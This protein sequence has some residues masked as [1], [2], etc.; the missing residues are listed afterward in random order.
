MQ[1]QP[2]LETPSSSDR[3]Q[4][5]EIQGLVAQGALLLPPQ[6]PVSAFIFLNVLEAFEEIPF[7]EGIRKGAML[8]GC[9][10]YLA[11]DQYQKQLADGRIRRDDLIAEL[12]ADLG[13]RAQE[14]VASLCT[15]LQL[16]EAMLAFALRSGPVDELRWFV[17]ETDALTRIRPEASMDVRERLIISTQQ[18]LQDNTVG[19]SASS[20]A[21][22]SYHR[23]LDDLLRPYGGS[24][25]TWTTEIWEE[26]TLKALWRICREGVHAVKAPWQRTELPIRHRDLLLDATGEDSDALV[27]EVLIRF[28]AAYADQGQA[29]WD[30]PLR[31]QGL[32]RAFIELYRQQVGPPDR[33]MRPLKS[34]LE[35]LREAGLTPAESILESLNLLDVP[36]EEWGDYL[37]A[38]LCALKGWA[39]LLYQMDVRSDRVPLPAKPGTLVEYVAVRLILERLALTHVAEATLPKFTSL[40]QLRSLAAAH[41]RTHP[42]TSVEQRALSVFQLSQLLGWSPAELIKLTTQDWNQLVAEI[43]SFNNL[44]RRRVFHNAFERR[45]RI[46]ALDAIAVR[47]GLPARRVERPRFQSCYCI[48][49]REESFRRHLE[50]FAPDTETFAAPGFYGVAMYYRGLTDAHFAAL[51]PIVVRPKHWMVEDAVYTLETSNR[52]TAQTRKAIG[53]ASHRMHRGSRG[54]TAG[55]LLTGTF[56]VLASIPLVARVLF[57]W[58]TSR[59]RRAAGWFVSPPPVTRLRME[60]VAELPGTEEDQIGFTVSEMAFFGE[61]LLRDIGLTH[62][63]SRLVIFFGHGSHCL[64]NPHKSAYDCGACTGSAGGPNARAL[65]AMLND[66]RIR[67]ILARNGLEIPKDTIFLGGLHNTAEDSVSFY[68]LDLLSKSH[69][70]DF[71]SARDTLEE[72][73]RRNAH[74]RCRRFQSARFDL[75]YTAAHRHVEQRAEDLAQTRPEYGNATNALCFVGRRERVRGLYMDRRAFMHSYDPTADDDNFTILGRILAPVVPVCEGINLT[76]FF[77]YIDSP[78]WGSGTKLPHNVTSLLGVMDGYQSD[79]RCGLPFQSVEIHEPVRL[80]FVIETTPEAMFKIMGRDKIVGRILRNK[81]AQLAIL[82]P[83]SDEIRVFENGEF[84]LYQPE[85]TRLDSAPT[86]LVWYRGHH[87]HLDFAL[88]DKG[89][90]QPPA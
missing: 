50:E 45:Y 9:R 68:D 83:N 31:E 52:L 8:F 90:V 79:M 28:C 72:V 74:E 75:S 37:T 44:E 25:R 3:E 87:E 16:R 23:V 85:T 69:Q 18:W 17:A 89:F 63:F 57:P 19:E 61:K 59:I 81:W 53:T 15:R 27:N 32:Y 34:E 67:E 64:N 77:S 22:H 11:E 13:A 78:G 82:D 80:L 6:G 40:D 2:S 51:C 29:D 4:A 60:R 39:A 12:N 84:H 10:P 54:A 88:I 42:L 76:Y 46:K 71:E 55:A 58:L 26:I 36:H 38:T 47:A 33:W 65:A 56:G 48:D 66:V 41:S 62:N 1:A 5:Q 86:S 14:T 43:E 35:R 7:D 73:C 20:A 24:L 30:L 70:K 21:H 49:A